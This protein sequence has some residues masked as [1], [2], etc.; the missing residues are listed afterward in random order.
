MEF[1]SRRKRKLVPTR[2]ARIA[3][4]CTNPEAI[5]RGRN[6]TRFPS[7]NGSDGC[8][9]KPAVDFGADQ[10]EE[11]RDRAGI[12]SELKGIGYAATSLALTSVGGNILLFTPV[13]DSMATITG[14]GDG[15]LTTFR[16]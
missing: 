1:A 2:I 16:E 12:G 13:W 6:A 10:F 15:A 3:K 4:P 8:P 11:M 5:I 9:R 7:G 14:F